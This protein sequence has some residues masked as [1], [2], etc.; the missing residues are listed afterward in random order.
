MVLMTDGLSPLD[1]EAIE[2]FTGLPGNPALLVYLLGSPQ[3]GVALMPDGSIATDSSGRRIDT[4]VDVAGMNSL[5]S[6]LGFRVIRL[7][8]DDSDINT[9]VRA[10]ESNAQMA[11]DPDAIWIDE[12]WWLLWP[13]AGLLLLSFRRGWVLP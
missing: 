1:T 6:R 9:L 5:G 3:G 8:T 4:T 7:T 2:T 12:A 13:M 10:I 11:E